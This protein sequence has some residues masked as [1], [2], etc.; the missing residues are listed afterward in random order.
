MKRLI[1]GDPVSIKIRDDYERKAIIKK[2]EKTVKCPLCNAKNTGHF[3]Y[4]RWD[5]RIG[6]NFNCKKSC[7][8]SFEYAKKHGFGDVKV[9]SNFEG[10]FINLFK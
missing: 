1:F 5:E 9:W 8:N 10:E 2:L 4:N 7:P 6:W 3:E